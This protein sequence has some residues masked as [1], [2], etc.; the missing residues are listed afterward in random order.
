MT[1][2]EKF[3]E[4]VGFQPCPTKETMNCDFACDVKYGNCNI[5]KYH[6]ATEFDDFNCH[7]SQWWMEEYKGSQAYQ[8][9]AEEMKKQEQDLIDQAVDQAYTRGYKKAEEDYYI[10]TEKDRESSYQLGIEVG[11]NEAWE[12]ASKVIKMG[13][14]SRK[15]EVFPEC[16]DGEYPFDKVSAS[17]AIE[18]IKA[19]EEKKQEIKVGDEVI[20]EEPDFTGIVLYVDEFVCV[21]TPNFDIIRVKKEQVKKVG[22][23]IKIADVLARL[24]EGYEE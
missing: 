5:C 16:G 21:I 22:H 2:S 18:K 7:A 8:Y 19:Y 17:E 14:Y 24:K 11:R 6:R 13:E 23:S 15:F 9:G 10:Q 4:I 1:N 12:A 20:F 3:K